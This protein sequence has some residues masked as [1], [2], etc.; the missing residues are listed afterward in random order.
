MILLSALL[1]SLTG[2]VS[3]ERPVERAAV[4]VSAVMTVAQAGA[5]VSRPGLRPVNP[6]PQL[7][8]VAQAAASSVW[9]T[10][11]RSARA[12]LPLHQSWLI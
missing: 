7:A 8:E 11:V 2:L 9:R 12:L 3:G 1:A 10:P 5:A 6:L 4:E